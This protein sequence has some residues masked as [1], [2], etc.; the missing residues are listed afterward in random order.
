MLDAM[1]RDKILM[2]D[3]LRKKQHYYYYNT[4]NLGEILMETMLQESSEFCKLEM[5]QN[6]ASQVHQQVLL[7]T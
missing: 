4:S 1:V 2:V 3:K 5:Q 7:N 6:W